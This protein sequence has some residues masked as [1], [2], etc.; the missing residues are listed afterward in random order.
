MLDSNFNELLTMQNWIE[1]ELKL[2]LQHQIADTLASCLNRKVDT[3]RV[4]YS[5]LQKILDPTKIKKGINTGKR[6]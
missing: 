6:K 3:R 2:K 5:N 4:R 1:K